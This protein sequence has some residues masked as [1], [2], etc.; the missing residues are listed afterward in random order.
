ST[1]PLRP[2]RHPRRSR[3]LPFALWAGRLPRQILALPLT[4]VVGAMRQRAGTRAKDRDRNDSC[5]VLDD[6]LSDGERSMEEHRERVSAATTATTLGEL[7]SLVSD[8]QTSGA[9]V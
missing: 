4:V 5:Q 1:S 8:L 7:Q 9:P 2:L 3:C 6:A